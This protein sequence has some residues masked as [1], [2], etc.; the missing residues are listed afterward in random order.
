MTENL[1]K[2]FVIKISYNILLAVAGTKERCYANLFT[3]IKKDGYT[4]CGCQ[5]AWRGDS[6]DD[7]KQDCYTVVGDGSPFSYM[8]NKIKQQ[9]GSTYENKPAIENIE[10]F[11]EEKME[12]WCKPY[13]NHVEENSRNVYAV[14]GKNIVCFRIKEAYPFR[15]DAPNPNT[16]KWL[17]W[18]NSLGLVFL[19]AKKKEITV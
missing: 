2:D 10:T 3:Y 13:P 14:N 4:V 7:N 6:H 5:K 1:S 12:R 9:K 8:F 15:P 18:T 11:T 19:A 17:E 16:Y